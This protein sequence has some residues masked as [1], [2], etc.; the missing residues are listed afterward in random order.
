MSS[1]NSR[2]RV[3]FAAKTVVTLDHRQTWLGPNLQSV[4]ASSHLDSA[5][6][7]SWGTLRHCQELSSRGYDHDRRA[8]PV[9]LLPQ[10]AVHC[11]VQDGPPSSC[12]QNPYRTPRS[13][14]Q[15]HRHTRW[16]NSV[17]CS[18]PRA[19]G[20][21]LLVV[22]TRHFHSHCHHQLFECYSYIG[23]YFYWIQQHI[24]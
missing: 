19:Q 22:A 11:G 3:T 21:K 17:E 20:H 13:Q 8:W 14:G 2:T 10:S 7:L 5:T 16:V 18:L 1:G 24:N 4:L 15:S 12:E 23:V 9:V 6:G